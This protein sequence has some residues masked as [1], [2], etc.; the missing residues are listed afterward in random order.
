MTVK[1]LELSESYLKSGGEPSEVEDPS[2]DKILLATSD[3]LELEDRLADYMDAAKEFTRTD[4]LLRA[5]STYL[6]CSNS[7]ADKGTKV[8]SLCNLSYV[9]TE[10]GELASAETQAELAL[11][12]DSKCIKAYVRLCVI[13]E[14]R[15]DFDK[16]RIIC[17]KALQIDPSCGYFAQK[18]SR[19]DALDAKSKSSL[20]SMRNLFKEVMFDHPSIDSLSGMTLDFYLE[21][22]KQFGM[23]YQQTTRSY[24][25]GKAYK[26]ESLRN[27]IAT[28][29]VFIKTSQKYYEED[30]DVAHVFQMVYDDLFRS[31]KLDAVSC[32]RFAVAIP[33]RFRFDLKSPGSDIKISNGILVD[34]HSALKSAFQLQ[35]KK[36]SVFMNVVKNF[37]SPAISALLIDEHENERIADAVVY[38][39]Y[40]NDL[41]NVYSYDGETYYKLRK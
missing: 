37:R 4:E 21:L 36:R 41:M 14:R 9:M 7:T 2:A 26:M 1:H 11:R 31:D 25:V 32:D 34:V 12:M 15:F 30:V 33:R 27:S 28:S 23:L 38:G 24:A 8:R 39:L 17:T 40:E 13:E 5:K 20:N 6:Y 3:K 18:L 16:L 19:C 29:S 10:L 22:K 35:Y